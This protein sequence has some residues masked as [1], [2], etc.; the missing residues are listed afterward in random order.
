[1]SLSITAQLTRFLSQYILKRN[2]H[3]R[4]TPR[5]GENEIS[6]LRGDEFCILFEIHKLFIDHD[7]P[8]SVTER[9]G[10]SDVIG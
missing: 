6:K 3:F 1:M 4:Q 7:V 9:V 8:Y 5:Q 10:A 2:L